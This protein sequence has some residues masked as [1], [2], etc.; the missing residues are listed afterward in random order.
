MIPYSPDL[1]PSDY[2]LFPNLEKCLRERKF[3]DDDD[4][5]RKEATEAYFA[6]QENDY[7]IY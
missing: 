4:D 5:M 7:G 3:Q 1:A 6:E 2:Y